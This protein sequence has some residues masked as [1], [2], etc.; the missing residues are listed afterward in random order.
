MLVE[1]TIIFAH[2]AQTLNGIRLDIFIAICVTH[3]KDPEV[4]Y[5]K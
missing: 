3:L 1:N 4:H 5:H 2:I